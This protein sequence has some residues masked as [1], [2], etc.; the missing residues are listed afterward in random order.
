MAFDDVFETREMIE[1]LN[2]QFAPKSFLLNTYF[3]RIETHDTSAIDIDII[4]GKRRL[5]PFVSPRAKGRI[6]KR[7][8]RRLRTYRPPYLKPK[9]TTDAE[10]ALKR[11]AGEP[12]Y[13]GQR[14][15]MDRAMEILA[16]DLSDLTMTI[17]RREEWMAAQALFTGKIVVQGVTDDGDDATVVDDEIDFQMAAS[18]Q[19]TL[20]GNALW[21]DT[22]NS[23]PL[24]N[25]RTWKR[26]IAQDSGLS[27][28]VAV[29][30]QNAMTA[31]LDHPKVKDSL[32]TRRID[33]GLIDPMELP[34][35]V[36]YWGYLK[37]PGCDV[38]TYD[39]WYLDDLGAEQPMVPV[40]KIIL[41]ATNARAIR[42][43]GAIQDLDAVDDGMVETRWYP[44]S[45]V[46]KDPSVRNILVQSA[47]MVVPHQVDGFLFAKTV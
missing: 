27:A 4:K 33:R 32:D 26:L 23:T 37:D 24:T 28:R 47:P 31:F 20:T 18:H 22:A 17:E 25:L 5:A 13:A 9:R 38:Y 46:T 1:A 35:G 11:T 39:E 40:D 36:T 42:H 6:V 10:Q 19:I 14:T 21:T 34:D 16:Q 29:F 7:D 45:W 15:P 8:G 43:Y 2:E 41:G 3:P 30:G 44:K 12:L